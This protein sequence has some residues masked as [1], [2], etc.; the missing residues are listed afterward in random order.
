VWPRHPPPRRPRLRPQVVD[1]S[2]GW[3]DSSVAHRPPHRPPW[4]HRRLPPPQPHRPP[5]SATGAA[6]NV[7]AVAAN[8]VV[9]A[10]SAAV[11]VVAAV[12][13]N[14]VNVKVVAAVNAVGVKA[15]R[16]VR[17][18]R[19]LQPRRLATPWPAKNVHRAMPSVVNAVNVVTAT[20][21]ATAEAVDRVP[22]ATGLRKPKRALRHWPWTA[23]HRKPWWTAC[24]A[25][26]PRQQPKVNVKVAVAVAAVVA[27]TVAKAAAMKARSP[28]TVKLQ[29]LAKALKQPLQSPRVKQ[30]PRPRLTPKAVN[31]KAVAAA[32]VAVAATVSAKAA[33]ARPP[34]AAKPKQH[35]PR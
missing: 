7:V 19:K 28:K 21:S 32:V 18:A 6:V 16:A 10:V 12:A 27:A 15:A 11:N 29:R 23:P 30:P 22:S 3:A 4:P 8:V 31:V 14:A 1:F 26:R 34:K 9:N 24:P 25:P 2:P 20:P 17:R 33:K 35:P 5:R 13:V